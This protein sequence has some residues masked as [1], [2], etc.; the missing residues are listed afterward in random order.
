MIAATQA[1]WQWVNLGH[2]FRDRRHRFI[3]H[4]VFGRLDDLEIGNSAIFLDSDL[5]ERRNFIAGSDVCCRL[6]PGAVETI[7]QHVAIPAEFG[8]AT[9][10]TGSLRRIRPVADVSTTCAC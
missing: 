8:C 3:Y 6:N 7:V 10:A 5:D 2:A 4:D 9:P 1:S